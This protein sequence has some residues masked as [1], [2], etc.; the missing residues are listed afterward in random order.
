MQL[1]DEAREVISEHKSAFVLLIP[2]TLCIL[3]SLLLIFKTK[4][5]RDYVQ[6]DRWSTTYGVGLVCFTIYLMTVRT[7]QSSTMLIAGLIGS[8]AVI[9]FFTPLTVVRVTVLSLTTSIGGGIACLYLRNDVRSEW[10]QLVLWMFA[11]NAFGYF[12]IRSQNA[13]LRR[14]FWQNEELLQQKAELDLAYQKE[15]ASFR[16]FVQFAE[17]VGHEFRNSLA[18]VKGK[19]QLIQ[20]ATRLGETPEKDA[21]VVIEHAVDRLNDLF[22][23]W[24]ESDSSAENEFTPRLRQTSLKALF[25]TLS[26]EMPT[27]TLHHI[28][29]HHSPELEVEIDPDLMIVA[30][31]NIISNAVKYSPGGGRVDV[32]VRTLSDHVEIAVADQGVGIPASER[33][34]VFEKYFRSQYDNGIPGLGLGLY[35]VQRIVTRHGGSVKAEQNGE[36][37]TIIVITLP[38]ANS[39]RP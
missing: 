1:Y 11:L 30:L 23:R 39:I 9:Y 2:R 19:A 28:H 21:P 5:V 35:M 25:D 8:V 29:F 27:S 20:L 37:G 15:K 6:L 36:K 24:L 22:N 4:R 12:G 34:L 13:N 17:L 14:I 32:S 10:L 18:V 38:V 26:N 16:R 3:W 7:Q 31:Q 33:D